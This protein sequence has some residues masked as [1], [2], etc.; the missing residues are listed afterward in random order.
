MADAAIDWA[1]LKSALGT[2]PANAASPP[3]AMGAEFDALANQPGAT[4]TSQSGDDD[5]KVIAS[6][7]QNQTGRAKQLESDF[8]GSY[9]PIRSEYA[10]K[11]SETPPDAPKYED[12]LSHQE[13]QKSIQEGK[14]SA[15]EW[16]GVAAGLSALIGGISKK[17]TLA[18]LHAMTGAMEG[19]NEGNAATAKQQME[20]FKQSNDAIIEHN[21]MLTDRY[22][23]ILN[24][25]KNSLD[26][27]KEQGAMVAT[28]YGDLHAWE[29]LQKGDIS[30]FATYLKNRDAMAKKLGAT[31]DSTF[32][33]A[34]N[35]ADASGY[36]GQK[37]IDSLKKTAPS[38]A[39]LFDEVQS[40]ANYDRPPRISRYGG[41][42]EDPEA[43]AVMHMVQ[44]YLGDKPYDATKWYGK[45]A[46]ETA[47][48]SALARSE[49]PHKIGDTEVSIQKV[50]HHLDTLQTAMDA[51]DSGDIRRVNA[52][53]QT[54]AREF[55]DPK[56][57]STDTA[58]NAVSQEFHRVYVPTGGVED[59]RASA[60][61]SISPQ[62]SPA[63]IKAA[64]KTMKELMLG[65]AEALKTGADTIRS[66]GNI[67]DINV[68]QPP[69]PGAKQAPDGKFY[70]PDP[71][72]PGK[73]LQV[74]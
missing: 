63:Q 51:L 56:I 29:E 37:Y 22:H 47:A 43:R 3:P 64:I 49:V 42:K 11:S 72:R 38:K 57:V 52:A 41:S 36:T 15:Q 1:S 25:K 24:N 45:I 70:V 60:A 28:E 8:K 59:E 17:H 19:L 67:E 54:L 4:A 68:P 61:S 44:Q 14:K 6:M 16:A 20:L 50:N 26:D 10:K 74:Q 69:V 27:I 66:G 32:E 31:G 71:N 23:D 5:S 39:S 73:Y 46:K 18:G 62:S 12:V 30:A 58:V 21:Q 40:I 7:L 13:L 9:D 33:S 65:Q 48:E 35:I 53:A 34:Q 55:G 2:A